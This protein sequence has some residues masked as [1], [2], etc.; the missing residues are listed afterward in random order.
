[1]VNYW[2]RSIY[3]INNMTAYIGYRYFFPPLRIRH[4][5]TKH[6]QKHALQ[7]LV[8]LFDGL[9]ALL[10][11][12]V[13]FVEDGGDAALFGE[14]GEWD[15]DCTNLLNGKVLYRYEWSSGFNFFESVRQESY[16]IF[17]I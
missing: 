3:A 5:I 10:A 6:I 13:G 16:Q 11:K 17:L 1:M 15:F 14:W 8:E 9:T 2:G 7:K 4:R 12:R